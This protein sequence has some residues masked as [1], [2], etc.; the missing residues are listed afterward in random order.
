VSV[1]LL[2]YSRDL[3]VKLDGIKQHFRDSLK[4]Y[5]E[6]ADD[7]MAA[8]SAEE[9]ATLWAGAGELMLGE[10]SDGQGLVRLT[11]VPAGAWLMLAWREE[12]HPAKAAR[13]LASDA[14]GFRDIPMS[15]GYSVVSY[16]RTRLEVRAGE[17]TEIDLNDR[18]VWL[19]GIRE[20]VYLANG[21]PSRSRR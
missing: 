16:W 13:S 11:R 3:E 4:R 17:A 1:V 20:N 10:V 19:T 6:A 5:M 12:T 2:P 7:V 21:R 9:E 18:N 15:A 8:R 14:R